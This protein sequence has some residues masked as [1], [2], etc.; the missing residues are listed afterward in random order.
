M[1]RNTNTIELQQKFNSFKWEMQS[2]LWV[3]DGCA[4]HGYAKDTAHDRQIVQLQQ[5]LQKLQDQVTLLST[6]LAVVVGYTQQR[7]PPV[8]VHSDAEEESES[9]SSS[10]S[11]SSSEDES[12]TQKSESESSSESDVEI[13]KTKRRR[14]F[15]TKQGGKFTISKRPL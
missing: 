7:L 3:L 5:S 2:R 4:Q 12:D 10:E 14:V 1:S 11:E 15:V 8:P 6:A 9:S 13:K